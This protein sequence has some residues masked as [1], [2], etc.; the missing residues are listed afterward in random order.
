MIYL[1]KRFK[2][3]LSEETDLKCPLDKD[4]WLVRFLRPCKFYPE[5]AFELVSHAFCIELRYFLQIIADFLPP[6]NK[7]S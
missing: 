6:G 2:L 1:Y 4:A 5:S 7:Y 3:F